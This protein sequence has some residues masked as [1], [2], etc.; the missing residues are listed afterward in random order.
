[1]RIFAEIALV[2]LTLPLFAAFDSASWMA[3][4]AEHLRE[5]DRL[6]AAYR[7]CEVAV[8][9]PAENVTVPVENHP[10]GSVKTSVFAKRAQFFLKE[11]LI[12]C[13]GVQIRQFREDGTVESTIDADNCVVDRATRS[14]WAEGQAS[15]SYREQADLSGA[16]VYFSASDEYV[17][18]STNV[19]LKADGNVLTSRAADYDR[20]AGVAMF[21]GS[22]EV[23]HEMKDQPCHLSCERAFAFIEGTN[24]VRRIVAL[25]GVRVTSDDKTGTCARAVYQKQDGTSRVTMFGDGTNNLARLSVAGSRKGTVE[26][27]RIRFWLDSEQVEVLDSRVTIETN[28][29]QLPGGMK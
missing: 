16:G 29:L 4:R 26:G 20:R 25:G 9:S 18:I 6:R 3:G 14:G 21:D 28:G 11:G 7:M 24:D 19:H 22:V 12:W 8:Q 5:A 13:S 15:A 23:V 10:D 2:G 17:M 27:R 1:M